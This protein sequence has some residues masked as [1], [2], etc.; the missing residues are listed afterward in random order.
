MHKFLYII[1]V[2]CF[3]DL[4]IQ[5]PIITP[6]AIS[7]GASEYTAGIIV[8]VYSLF[9]MVGNVFGG[10]FSDKIGRKNM[11][12]L[13]M[14]LQVVIILTY[15]I[16]PSVSLL[17]AIRVVHGFSS[18]L[19]TPAA[20]SLV[21]DIS[22]KATIGRSMALTGVSIGTAAVVGPALGGIISSQ[23]GYQAVYL[24]LAGIFVFGILLLLL[25]VKESTTEESRDI[26]YST[27]YW[28][29][30]KRPSL[31]VAYVSAFTLMVSNGSLAF[32]LP[33]KTASLGLS[34]Q[35]TGVMLS[36]FGI[37]AII[38]FASPLNR[39]YTR[40]SP[41]VLVASGIFIVGFSM[42]LLHM[43]PST[44]LV[45]MTMVI[46][47]AGFSLIFPSMNKIIG[48]N[49]EMHER[50]KA[51]GIFYSYFSIGSV[52]GSFLSGIFATYFETPF[53]FI[54]ITI[55]LLLSIIFIAHKKSVENKGA[56][57]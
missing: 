22:K 14:I 9:N 19:L 36:V 55:I 42:I 24:L 13:G 8:A 12:L 57:Q 26:H 21:A 28:Q 1:I 29:I 52:A 6:F 43:V 10:Y 32:G 2:I 50:G 47:G 41:V 51:N 53:L 30:I 17:I 23:A 45:Y 48:E 4:F 11:L 34:D 44:S 35:S 20:F 3:L 37:T 5:L 33:L 7:L 16:V 38:V 39:V 27:N 54:G 40:Y 25:T 46:Y 56:L 18:G 49:T 15:T 31:I